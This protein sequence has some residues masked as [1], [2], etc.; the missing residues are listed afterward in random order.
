MACLCMP[1]SM[2]DNLEIQ[3][4]KIISIEKF[5]QKLKVC[6]F[7]CERQLEDNSGRSF[8][9]HCKSKTVQPLVL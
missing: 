6:C 5:C 8:F 1:Q 3:K 2:S 7:I 4:F 9:M